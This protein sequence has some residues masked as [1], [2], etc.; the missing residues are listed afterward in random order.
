M[1]WWRNQACKNG[2][3]KFKKKKIE[4]AKLKKLKN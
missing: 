4:G 1:I 2:G 3:A